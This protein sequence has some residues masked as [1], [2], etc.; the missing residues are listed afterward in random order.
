GRPGRPGDAPLRLPAYARSAARRPPR[1]ARRA[2]PAR[3]AV[4]R[5]R[6]SASFLKSGTALAAGPWGCPDGA[7]RPRPDRRG[8]REAGPPRPLA[9]GAGAPGAARGD[10]AAVGGRGGGPGDRPRARAGRE[11]RARLARAL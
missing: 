1:R 5:P 7:I 8:A 2:A 11:D 6:L 3:A 9:D 10:R 4:G